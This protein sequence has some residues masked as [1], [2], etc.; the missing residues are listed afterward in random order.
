M[1][2]ECV[3][4]H[5]ASGIERLSDGAF[6][7]NQIEPGRTRQGA[8]G[9]Q[10]ERQ[11]AGWLAGWLT[12]LSKPP[13]KSNLREA[14]RRTRFDTD[15]RTKI[16]AKSP[17]NYGFGGQN[18]PR[19]TPGAPRE[20]RKVPRGFPEA[21]QGDPGEPQGV[22]ESSPGAP[23]VAQGRP[24]GRPKPPKGSQKHPPER[25]IESKTHPRSIS[26]PISVQNH[27]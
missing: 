6:V 19:S 2:A 11:A 1:L 22:P 10:I 8:D 4:L 5:E 13:S 14:V 12:A 9:S 3:G 16:D 17:K 20:P 7:S 21:T 23:K 18:P 15:F 24:K 27:I 25:K 26:K